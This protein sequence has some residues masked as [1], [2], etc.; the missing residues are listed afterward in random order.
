MYI[1][2]YRLIYLRINSSVHFSACV[3]ACCLS[4]VEFHTCVCM[5]TDAYKSL[6]VCLSFPSTQTYAYMYYICVCVC[7]LLSVYRRSFHLHQHMH[8]CICVRVHCCLSIQDF[9][10]H[11]NV[12]IYHKAV[13]TMINSAAT[14]A[15]IHT[16]HTRTNIYKHTYT[17]TY[18]DVSLVCKCLYIQVCLC[19]CT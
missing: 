12:Y 18:L 8:V 5:Y 15:H 2:I 3:M 6:V 17:R 9:S 10:N 14:H 4:T 7:S 16:T 11:M 13:T 19:T 1:Y